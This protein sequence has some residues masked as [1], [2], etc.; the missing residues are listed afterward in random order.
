MARYLL[1]L[2][3]LSVALLPAATA[4]CAEA[5]TALGTPGVQGGIVSASEP[6]AAQVG[7][8]VLRRGGNAV[9]AAVA[10]QFALNVVEPKSSG[11][12]GGGFMLIYLARRQQTVI[13]DARETAPAAATPDMFLLA[14]QPAQAFPFALSSTSGVA[15]GVPGTVRGVAM[16]LDR[17]GGWSFADTLQPAIR[18]AEQGFRVSADL[19]ASS[20]SERLDS[21][22]DNPAYATARAVFRP[23][24]RPLQKG[25]LLRQPELA[26]TLRLLAEQGPEAF[27]TGA[28]AA[29]IVA[30]QRHA[31]RV[32]DPADQAKLYGRMT[33]QDLAGYRAVLRTPLE[34][35]YRGYRIVTMPPPS[36]GGLATLQILKMLERLPIGDLKQGYGFSAPRTLHVTIEA[37]RLAFADVALWMG[38][39]DFAPVPVA[40]LLAAGYV[41]QRSALLDPDRRQAEVTAG[42]PRPFAQNRDTAPAR[43]A[44]VPTP[45]A[46]GGNTTH[47]TIVDRDGNIV[48]STAT[49]ESAWGTGL[50]VPGYGFLLNNELSDFNSA[51]AFTADA[52]QFNPGVNDVAPGKRPRSSMAPTLILRDRQPLA[53]YGSPGGATIVATVVG[54]A[55]NLIDHRLP[56]QEA[57][58]APR[59]AQTSA[60]GG[61]L[62]EQ[63]FSE[64]TMQAL[65][66]LGQTLAPPADIGSVQAVVIDPVSGYQYGGA[67]PR[68]GGTVVSVRREQI[69]G[70]S[71]KTSASP[72]AGEQGVRQ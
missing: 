53:A 42:D 65:T 51:P 52:G 67:D 50:M 17:W 2:L 25:A 8:E 16:A 18:L 22:P 36:A 46:E 58:A 35:D 15:V 71:A 1:L 21:E 39:A 27:Y 49:I 63:G 3:L 64:D 40:G 60:T 7:A 61:T 28:L 30:T 56:I 31:R 24:G 45:A 55:L 26:G 68:R 14:S 23:D 59:I 57:I 6:L 54:V 9:D 10:T 37:L 20:L 43:L 48:A 34:G 69:Q 62:R 38:D 19:A 70:G 44:P 11:I 4:C 72:P 13:V 12:G 47:F 33:L 32:A 66:A 5:G 29:A 41:Q